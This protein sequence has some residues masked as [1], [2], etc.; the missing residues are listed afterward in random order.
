MH[1]LNQEEAKEQRFA[2]GLM[3]YALCSSWYGDNKVKKLQRWLHLANSNDG[4]HEQAYSSLADALIA[5]GL[6]A[7]DADT[8]IDLNQKNKLDAAFAKAKATDISV[9]A[10]LKSKELALIFYSLLEGSNHRYV[11]GDQESLHSYDHF[12]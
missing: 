4:R 11:F 6:D 12:S 9:L 8:L 5:M 2:L 3:V 7:S 10:T 1:H